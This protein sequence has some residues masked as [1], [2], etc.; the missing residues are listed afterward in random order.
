MRSESKMCSEVKQPRLHDLTTEIL[1][2]FRLSNP[3]VALERPLC[4]KFDFR[5]KGSAALQ[6]SFC[7]PFTLRNA[8]KQHTNIQIKENKLEKLLSPEDFSV[9]LT[10]NLFKDSVCGFN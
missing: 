6:T 7:C 10:Q 4:S 8:V 1:L 5:P 2:V 3:D 9:T